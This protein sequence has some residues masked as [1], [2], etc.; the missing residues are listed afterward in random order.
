MS[1]ATWPVALEVPPLTS[2]TDRL[3]LVLGGSVARPQL[4]SAEGERLPHLTRR[5]RQVEQ[6]FDRPAMLTMLIRLEDEFG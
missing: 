2:S 3:L 1:Q 4:C 5:L 6:P